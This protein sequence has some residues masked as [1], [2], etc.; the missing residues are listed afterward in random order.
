MDG[1]MIRALFFDI[2]GTLADNRTHQIHAEDIQSL[3]ALKEKG[4]LL[5]AAT[6][7]DL[8]IPEEMEI[9]EPVRHLFSGFIDVNGQHILL[10]DGT[11]IA[12]HPIDD[13]DFFAIRR[14]CEENGFSMLYRNGYTNHL[15]IHTFR[16]ERYWQHMGLRMPQIRPMDPGYHSVP[17]LCI[18][19]S[20]EEEET[21]LRPLMRHTWAARITEDL[22]DMIPEGIGKS[23]GIREICSYFGIRAGQTMAFGDGQNDLDMIHAAGIGVAMGNGKE[24]IKA[25]AAYVTAS[26]AE[27]GVTRALRHF[28]LI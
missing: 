16:A 17:K 14:C 26:A 6:G 23:S 7:R 9:L 18:H 5:F 21:L 1:R 25:A 22:I 3:A 13:S 24:N 10:A 2:D 20:P 15:T 27:A 28:K 12:D 11:E 8:L 19:I 4:Y